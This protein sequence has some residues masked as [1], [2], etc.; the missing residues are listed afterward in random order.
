MKREHSCI[1]CH[2][3]FSIQGLP[4][5]R[6]WDKCAREQ[7]P[8]AQERFAIHNYCI[9]KEKNSRNKGI[10]WFLSEEDVGDLISQAGITVYDIGK[11]ADKY[12]LSR[13]NDA[14]EYVLGNVEFV[15][16][17]ENLEQQWNRPE[18]REMMIEKAKLEYKERGRDEH[19]RF[20]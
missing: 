5:E 16:Q 7:S 9:I 3:V 13:Y 11:G 1:H 20:V 4:M 18:Y 15:T 12:Q 19:S 2:K 17:R 10:G 14:G 6:H 8:E